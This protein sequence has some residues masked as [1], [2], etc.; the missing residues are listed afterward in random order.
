MAEGSTYE[1]IAVRYAT[2]RTRKSQLYYR[3]QDYGEPDADSSLD[4]F[5]WVLR[6]GGRTILVDTGFEPEEGAARGRT[7]LCPP[8]EAVA[9]LGI[10]P[11]AVDRIL[12]THFHYDHIGNVAAFP[13]AEVLVPERELAFWTGPMAE[14]FQFGHHADRAGIEHLREAHRAG[15]ARTF[16]P[17]DEVAPGIEALCVGGHSPGQQVLVV[18]GAERRVVLASD[19]VHFYEELELERPFSVIAD[20]QQMYEGY[21]T[22]RRLCDDGAVLLPGHDPAV[23]DRFPDA[24]GDAAGIG[25]RVA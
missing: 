21:D 12:V 13:D 11:G 20:L 2:M 18:E 22:V 4:Y 17:G 16:A 24:G 23:V 19:A 10:E 15:R 6:G 5:F 3:F 9:R 25:L 7:C 1:V 14:R 8:V